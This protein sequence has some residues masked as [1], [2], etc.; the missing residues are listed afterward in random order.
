MS[1]LSPSCIFSSSWQS[2]MDGIRGMNKILS[3]HMNVETPFQWIAFVAIPLSPPWLHWTLDDGK[4]GSLELV[5]SVSQWFT[6]CLQC[7]LQLD[8]LLINC[9]GASL[10]FGLAQLCTRVAVGVMSSVILPLEKVLYPGIG[11]FGEGGFRRFCQITFTHIIG[12]IIRIKV[13][14]WDWTIELYL[15]V[16]G[17]LMNCFL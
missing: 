5:Y 11:F 14:C 1:L 10:L 4:I 8:G 2:S 7:H 12:Q 3:Q 16:L 13:G 17:I 6:R 9:P 15:F